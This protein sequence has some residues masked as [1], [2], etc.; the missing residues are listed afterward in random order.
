M[1]KKLSFDLFVKER[2][3]MQENFKRSSKGE[4]FF[5]FGFYGQHRVYFRKRLQR[6]PEFSPRKIEFSA[7]VPIHE[8]RHHK[9]MDIILNL[10]LLTVQKLFFRI[11][12]CL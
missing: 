1:Y 3:K 8:F 2:N 4:K 5:T 11:V 7:F 10:V 9:T 12:F 6:M